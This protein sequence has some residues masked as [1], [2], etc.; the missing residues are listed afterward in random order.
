MK[1]NLD[2]DNISHIKRIG[3]L[4]KEPVVKKINVVMSPS[5]NGFHVRCNLKSKLSRLD[6]FRLRYKYNDDRRRLLR[7]ILFRPFTPDILHK[8]KVINGIKCSE[9]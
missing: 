2:W 7:D 5:F 1:L 6:I 3:E 4:S 8:A 9:K